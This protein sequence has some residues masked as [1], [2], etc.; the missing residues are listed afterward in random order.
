MVLFGDRDHY[1]RLGVTASKL[2]VLFGICGLGTR[3]KLLGTWEI[4]KRGQAAGPLL[5][6][7]SLEH[8]PIALDGLFDVW[9][10]VC[11]QG[12]RDSCQVTKSK[13]P[14]WLKLLAVGSALGVVWLYVLP[15]IAEIPSVKHHIELL[16]RRN[17]NAGAMFYT[18]VQENR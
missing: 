14:G 15:H 11:G 5:D 7:P 18:E 10:V 13:P 1:Q 6:R 3:D 9:M 2:A 4:S 16:E 17:I 12:E 8:D